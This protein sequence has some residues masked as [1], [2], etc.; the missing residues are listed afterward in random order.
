MDSPLIESLNTSFPNILL[1]PNVGL[2]FRAY[3][4][5]QTLR[6]LKAQL[7]LA[8]EVYNTLRWADIYFHERDGKGLTQTELRQLALD[9]R[10]QDEQY[11]Q[12]YSQTAQQL[13]D[14]YY[15]ARQR[16]FEGLARFPKEKKAHK[17]Y[18][19][20][21]PQKG[22][23][24]LETKEIRTRSKKN[25]K[26]VITLKLSNLG[27]FNVI[28]HRDFP[29][30]KVKRVVVKLTRS[31][32]V[33]ISFIVEGYEFPKLPSTGKAVAIDVGVEKLLT[34]S[35]GEY[36]PNQRPYEKALNKVKKLH[37]ALS[38][39]KFLSRN[40]FKAKIKL[41]RAY[42]HLKNLRKD[43]YMKLGKWFA[44]HYDVVVMEDIQVKQLVGK[45]ERK[46]RMRLHDVA[47][48]ELRSI[49]EYQLKKYGK[50]IR[51]VDPVFTSMTC[52]RCGYIKNDITLA[53]RVFACPC[54]WVADRDYNASLNILRR[55]GWEPPLVP[56]ELRPLPIAHGQGGAMKQEAPP[57]RA[58]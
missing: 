55:S 53:D 3:T 23:K 43:I 14:R 52:A 42:E 18:S 56:V 46:L 20:V 51:F 49:M 29:L 17:W 31:G 10:K 26:K 15:E 48:H 27:I 50:N 24:I 12:L 7:K 41:A 44:E 47:I 33:Y 57:F 21:Y 8:C 58:E 6:A 19:L 35:D 22:W 25:K 54:G 38:R 9:L 4:G 13:A 34:T 30:D 28:V 40:W 5:E 1:M 39:K 37:K 36:V 11:Q 2:R 16:F 32:R 45:S